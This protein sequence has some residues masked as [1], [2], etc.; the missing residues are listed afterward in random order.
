MNEE[1]RHCSYQSKER[2]T[3]ILCG[4]ELLSEKAKRLAPQKTFSCIPLAISNFLKNEQVFRNCIYG[5]QRTAYSNGE[6]LQDIYDGFFFPG[7]F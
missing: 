6:D 4:N 2:N 5:I 1:T 7:E 3:R